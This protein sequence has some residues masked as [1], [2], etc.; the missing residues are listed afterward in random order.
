MQGELNP[1]PSTV[2]TS[3]LTATHVLLAALCI[4]VLALYY[5]AVLQQVFCDFM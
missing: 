2:E 3:D 4:F 1:Q 5:L